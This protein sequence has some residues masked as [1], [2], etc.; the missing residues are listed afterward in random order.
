MRIGWLTLPDPLL[1]QRVLE[2]KRN[3]VTCESGV[4]QALALALLRDAGAILE[5][6]R[7][8]VTTGLETVERWM[9]R[10]SRRVWDVVSGA[11]LEETEGRDGPSRLIRGGASLWLA[12]E[13]TS[14]AMQLRPLMT[15]FVAIANGRPKTPTT[16]SIMRSADSTDRTW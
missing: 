6:M 4:T 14:G 11:L 13:D 7:A 12:T 3:I 10:E 15:K 5:R 8:H 9:G 1:R 2:A 16:F